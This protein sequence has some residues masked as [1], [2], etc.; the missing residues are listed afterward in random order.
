MIWYDMKMMCYVCRR[1]RR[2]ITMIHSDVCMHAMHARTI[3]DDDSIDRRRGPAG[4]L[5]ER[6]PAGDGKED[7]WSRSFRIIIHT[8]F[9]FLNGAFYVKI[10][11]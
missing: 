4:H 2:Q 6:P 10:L 11:I 1:G 8:F 5:W 3:I 7:S 9:K